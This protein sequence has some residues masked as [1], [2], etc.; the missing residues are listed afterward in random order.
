MKTSISF[1]SLMLLNALACATIH[2]QQVAD[3]NFNPRID[4]P[5]YGAGRGPVVMLDEAHFNFHTAEG[6]YKPFADLLR[7]DGYR[8]LPFKAKFSKESLKEGNI[9]VI[10]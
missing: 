10:A 7:R 2:A 4:K 6:R 3:P 5:G 1:L 8:V 9:L